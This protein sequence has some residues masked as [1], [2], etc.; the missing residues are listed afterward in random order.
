MNRI[1]IATNDS[2]TA[3]GIQGALGAAG[4]QTATVSDAN[5]LIEFCQQHQPDLIVIDLEL[6]GGSIW[7]A[8]KTLRSFANTTSIPFLGLGNHLSDM[9]T[10]HAQSVGFVKFAPKPVNAETFVADVQSVLRPAT[11][12]PFSESLPQAATPPAAFRPIGAETSGDGNHVDRIRALTDEILS[13]TEQL[14]PRVMSFG[15]DGPEL[16]GYII[17]SGADIDTKL[18]SIMQNG[19]EATREALYDHELRHDFRNMIGSVTGFAELILMEASL[20]DCD[21]PPLT[22]IRECSRIFVDLLDQQKAEA[23]V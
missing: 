2:P 17:G 4:F 21:R 13:L 5:Q 8:A 10:L 18:R 15:P 16:F 22:R 23:V 9:E 6:P 12:S 7:A 19:P 1:L 3:Q 11:P 20:P 14:K